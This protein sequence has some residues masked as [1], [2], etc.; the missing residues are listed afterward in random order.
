MA[1][2]KNLQGHTYHHGF[3]VDN[4]PSK[5]ELL[6]KELLDRNDDYAQHWL[7]FWNDALRNDYTGTGYITGGRFAVTEWLY[8]ALKTNKPYDVFVRELVSPDKKS[9]GFIKG[10]QWRGTVNASQRG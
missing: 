7:S 5:R 9:V 4:N 8:D 3:V 10:I 6:V 1:S 2:S